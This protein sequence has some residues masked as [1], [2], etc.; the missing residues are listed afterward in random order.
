MGKRKGGAG[1]A[2]PRGPLRAAGR[3]SEAP[4]LLEGPAGGPLNNE[5]PAGPRLEIPVVGEAPEPHIC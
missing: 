1:V 2:E 4:G 5:V 3:L